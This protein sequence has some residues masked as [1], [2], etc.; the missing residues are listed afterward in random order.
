V[1]RHWPAPER[2][3][4]D[5]MARAEMPF[6]RDPQPPIRP[7]LFRQ[8]RQLADELALPTVRATTLTLMQGALWDTTIATQ[9]DSFLNTLGRQLETALAIAERDGEIKQRPDADQLPALLIGPLVYRT[10]ME[11]T[12]VSDAMLT[13]ILDSVL[14]NAALDGRPSADQ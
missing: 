14:P 4:L 10:A 5:V 6:F 8:L 13:A 12:T 11:T 7:W 2:L 9:R 1:Y 3:L